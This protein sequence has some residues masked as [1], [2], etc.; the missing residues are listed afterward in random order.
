MDAAMLERADAEI[1]ANLPNVYSLLVV[2]GGDIVHE[3]YFNDADASTVFDQRS[4]TKSVLSAVIG[5]L[6]QRGAFADLDQPILALLPDYADIGADVRKRSITLRHLLGMTGGF[7]WG[8]QATLGD[9]DADWVR[10]ALDQP[11]ELEPG[12]AF[13][14]NSIAMHPLSAL[15]TR[16]GGQ[17]AAQIANATLFGKIGMTP[18]DWPSD[19]Q[20]NSQGFSGLVFTSRDM[21]RFGYLYLN[22]G[23]WDGEQVVPLDWVRETTRQHSPHPDGNNLGYGHLWWTTKDKGHDAYFA[24]GYGWQ[25]IQVV[26]ALDLVIVMTGDPQLPP[27]Q[28]AQSRYIITDYVIPAVKE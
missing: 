19:P 2:R 24:A 7:T 26:P 11:L 5:I 13:R 9:G 1:K 12:K 3:T 23:C 20:A 4:V 28:V 27:D 21:A 8:E 14:Y 25:Y 15:I 22:N 18:P 17:T 10:A 6:R 16:A